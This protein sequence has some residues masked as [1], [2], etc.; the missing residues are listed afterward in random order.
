MLLLILK[1]E[2]FEI[3]S[4]QVSK[5]NDTSTPPVVNTKN[6]C[7]RLAVDYFFKCFWKLFFFCFALCCNNSSDNNSSMIQ[8]QEATLARTDPLPF[9]ISLQQLKKSN[10]ILTCKESLNRAM[11]TLG[12]EMKDQRLW[13]KASDDA[14]L[15][16]CYHN[17]INCDCNSFFRK[18]CIN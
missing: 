6:S 7:S 9:T 12:L 16:R 1:V 18:Q 15:C 5:Q 17:R 3:F 11:T 14:F 4:L 2:V 13:L 10:Q 8:Q